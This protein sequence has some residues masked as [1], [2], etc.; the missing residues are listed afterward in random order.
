MRLVWCFVLVGI[1]STA[2]A[3]PAAEKA[4]QDGRAFLAQNKLAEACE[5]F[6]L[7]QSLEPRVGTLLNLGDCEER[8]G[9]IATA[10][11]AFSEAKAL[12]RSTSDARG[13]DAETRAT[14]LTAKLP[15][16]TVKIATKPTGLVVKRDDKDISAALDHEVPIDPGT[17]QL[18]ASAPGFVTWHQQT[19]VAIGQHA[20]VE[21]PALVADPNPIPNGKP[22]GPTEPTQ[23]DLSPL[24]A[25]H[26]IGVGA[27]IGFSTDS[28]LIFGVRVP[29]QL[30][31]AGPGAIRAV[32]TFFYTHYQDPN[33]N[34]HNQELYALGIGVEYTAPLSPKFFVA[35]GA[36]LGVDIIDDSYENNLQKHGWGAVRLSPTIRIGPSLDLGVHAQAVITS[37]RVVG[38]GELGV[39]Y[40]FW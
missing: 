35:A 12:A 16:I 15:Y 2:H 6:R 39:D 34:S 1:A 38:L 28:D 29:L 21:I 24:A 3:D 40:F 32:P 27:A 22:V 26:H 18:E 8:R 36:G 13:A 19:Q 23:P 33:D 5:A 9:K 25:T 11:E 4:F 14:A 10:W 37:D 17:Y 20:V 30:G 31:A 7:S